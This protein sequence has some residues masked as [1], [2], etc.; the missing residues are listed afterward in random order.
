MLPVIRIAAFAVL[1]LSLLSA[2]I[3]VSARA[4]R[5]TNGERLARGLGPARPRR[6]Y[7]GTRTSKPCTLSLF[8]SFDVHCPMKMLHVRF[9]L[10]PPVQRA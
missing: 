4:V 6:L 3:D 1:I 8:S 9:P 10:V 2:V 7:A 5:E